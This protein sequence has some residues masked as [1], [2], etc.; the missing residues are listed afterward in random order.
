MALAQAG[1]IGT[2]PTPPVAPPSLTTA[3]PEHRPTDIPGSIGSERAFGPLSPGRDGQERTIPV[4]GSSERGQARPAESIDPGAPGR[5]QAPTPGTVDQLKARAQAAAEAAR[6][7]AAS[8]ATGGAATMSSTT[9]TATSPPS[10]P[11]DVIQDLTQPK[12]PEAAFSGSFT[13]SV[14]IEVPAFRGLEPKLRLS[15]DSNRSSSYGG[16]RAG[17][18]GVGWSLEGFPEIVRTSAIDGA[19]RFD[20]T[21]RYS[22]DGE[23][24]E[25][26][27][28]GMTAASCLAFNTISQTDAY[29]TRFESYQRI[30]YYKNANYWEV[31]ARDGTRYL[32]QPVAQWV[33]PAPPYSQLGHSYRWLL[34]QAIDTS[35]NTVT[36]SYSCSTVPV[37]VPTT[38]AY[39]GSQ[40]SL[41]WE[42]R[43]DSQSIAT[44]LSVATLAQRLKLVTVSNAGGQRLRVYRMLYEQSAATGFSR[45][46]EVWQYGRDAVIVNGEVTAGSSLPPYRF[47]YQNAPAFAFGNTSNWQPGST[48]TTIPTSGL[49]LCDKNLVAADFN[50]DQKDDLAAICPS[51]QQAPSPQTAPPWWST[52]HLQSRSLPAVCTPGR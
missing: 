31:T 6:A 35:G 44:A 25:I 8:G 7:A 16:L 43:P 28:T 21:D 51:Q 38:I 46:T 10:A 36:Y 42:G 1:A 2:P 23:Q 30:R 40:V 18:L 5:G 15:Y 48:N 45:L 49:P 13:T 27:Q 22:F 17:Q 47:R 32:F 3:A 20:A 19:P 50:G 4:Q 37:C 34:A 9:S 41:L 14:P 39:G 52:P 11:K 24:L 12:M 26:C 33:N 29:T